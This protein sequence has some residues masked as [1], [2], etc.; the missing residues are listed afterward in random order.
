LPI[1]AFAIVVGFPMSYLAPRFDPDIFVSYSHG[2]PFGGRAPL[3][4][5]SQALVGR[6]TD[7]LRA[8]KTEFDSLS[9]WM[10]P[11]LDPTVQLTDDLRAKASQCG[12]LIIFMS[13]RYLKS[14][15]CKDELNWFEGQ[16]RDRLGPDGR[17]FVIKAQ[18]TD[19]KDWPK[20][21]LDERGYA[22]TGF[23]FFDPATGEPRGFQ[24]PKPN[25]E[26]YY[27]E[28]SRLRVWLTQRLRE[29]RD[30][31][32]KD[33]QTQQS[34]AAARDSRRPPRLYLHASPHAEDARAEVELA[35]KADGVALVTATPVGGDGLKAWELEAKVRIEA[36]KRCDALA[37]LRVEHDERFVDDLFAIGVDERERMT[38]V[39]GSPP[40]CAVLDRSGR[41][42][43]IDVAPFGIARFDVL[44][45]DW[46]GVFRAWLDATRAAP[47]GAML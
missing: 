3:R 37:I 24:E 27:R 28:L 47:A 5:W 39:R 45:P 36:A 42:L 8:L 43:P 32:A 15:W 7:G 4:D 16:L 30:C 13:E 25:D 11:E 2:A 44:P 26:E 38:G 23:S 10:D 19:R 6:L 41:A 46:P 22:M 12:V 17:V 20:L 40:P 35:L 33:A 18:R 1:A 34:A 29:L 31:V 14:S 21:L 9:V